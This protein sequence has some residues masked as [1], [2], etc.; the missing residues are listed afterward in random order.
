MIERCFLDYFEDFTGKKM[1]EDAF[2]YSMK[3]EN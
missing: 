1:Q 2:L 3:I